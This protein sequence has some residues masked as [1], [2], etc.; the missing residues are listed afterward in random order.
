VYTINKLREN[1]KTIVANCNVCPLNKKI[2]KRGEGD[3]FEKCSP[4]ERISMNIFGPFDLDKYKH[5]LPN[6]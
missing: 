4:F 3:A 5:E 6:T 1:I 2:V